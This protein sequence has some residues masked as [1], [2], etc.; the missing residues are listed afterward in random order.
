M[1]VDIDFNLPT[2]SGISVQREAILD[3]GLEKIVYVETAD[4]MFESRV[5]ELGTTFD[6]RVLIQRGLSKGDRVVVTGNFLLDSESRV[7][8]ETLRAPVRG[9]R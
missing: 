1:Y 6:D 4:H 9:S 3:K 7:R 8:G 5:V 2:P